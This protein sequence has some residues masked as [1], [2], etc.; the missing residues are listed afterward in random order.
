MK[1]QRRTTPPDSAQFKE[2]LKSREMKATPQRMAVHEAMLALVHASA[3]SVHEY[4]K[5]NSDC[6]ITAA[7][8]YNILG[9]LSDKGIYSRRMSQGSKMFFDIV[10]TPHLHLYDSVNDEYRNIEDDGLME[11]V[12]THLKNHKYKSYKVDG[13]DIQIVCHPN[14]KRKRK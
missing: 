14:G 7:S 9:E 8:V 4:I 2:L 11:L 12:L 6:S 5:E 10:K 1:K 13:I 3:D